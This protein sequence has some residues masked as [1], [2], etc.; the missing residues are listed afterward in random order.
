M[1]RSLVLSFCLS[2]LAL[3]ASANHGDEEVVCALQTRRTTPVQATDDQTCNVGD[4]VPC[5]GSGTMCAGDQCCPRGADGK[6]F[7]C[8]SATPG[9]S[10]CE[11]DAKESNCVGYN[12]G[13][14]FDEQCAAWRAKGPKPTTCEGVEYSYGNFSAC[15]LGMLPVT[16]DRGAYCVDGE[17]V[18]C[19]EYCAKSLLCSEGFCSDAATFPEQC[20]AW[21][22][23]TGPKPSTCE[24]APEDDACYKNLPPISPE[25]GTFCVDGALASCASYCQQTHLCP[26]GFCGSDS[27]GDQCQRW[28]EGPAPL[29]TACEG[30][31]LEGCY[32]GMPVTPDKG[33]F[34]VDGQLATCDEYCK[35]AGG[36]QDGFCASS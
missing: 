12:S 30:I 13:P 10:K 9:W 1:S 6:T 15:Y 7:P 36:C 19:E 4:H 18:T 21:I 2:A 29:P 31:K 33:S 35:A 34:C 16:P 8:P 27:Y 5:P 14:T 24:G 32:I 17:I 11:K 28:L 20:D 22:D 3:A 23:G 25:N 26:K